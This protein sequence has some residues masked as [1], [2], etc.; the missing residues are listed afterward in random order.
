MPLKDNINKPIFK[1][2]EQVCDSAKTIEQAISQWLVSPSRGLNIGFNNFMPMG[3]LAFSFILR[4]KPMA[5]GNAILDKVLKFYPNYQPLNENTILVADGVFIGSN[6]IDKGDNTTP[7][8][9]DPEWFAQRN[10]R[11]GI[12]Y[13]HQAE[14]WMAHPAAVAELV[15]SYALCSFGFC[16]LK[17]VTKLSKKYIELTLVFLGK[18]PDLGWHEKVYVRADELIDFAISRSTHD[19][20]PYESR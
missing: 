19:R 15:L 14:I 7:Y 17:L 8:Q 16:D 3:C 18:E 1:E 10:N 12:D 6:L 5:L 2:I 4:G 9:P 13:N 20:A 11:I